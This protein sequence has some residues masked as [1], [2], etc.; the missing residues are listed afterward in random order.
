MYV[1]SENKF[2]KLIKT[3]T[4][5]KKNLKTWLNHYRMINDTIDILDPYIINLGIDFIVKPAT[6]T[7]RF[8]VLDDCLTALKEKFA[9]A[10]YI[11]EQIYI[12]DIYSDLKK[13]TG[14]L[15]V[16]SV[17]LSSK[18]GT[19]YSSATIDVN[20]NL[21]PDGSYLMVPKNTIVEIKFPETDIKGKVR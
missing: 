9:T 12:S 14:V 17:T 4:T 10:F 5:I 19:N 13:V 1:I 8:T 16:T 7:N 21:S 2:G 6:N 3:N 15:D 18:S 11:G 20:Q